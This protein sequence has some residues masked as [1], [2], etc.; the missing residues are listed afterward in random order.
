[1]VFFSCIHCFW[2]C[3]YEGDKSQIKEELF[4][5]SGEKL[6]V[7]RKWLKKEKA[8]VLFNKVKIGLRIRAEKKKKW[9]W[10]LLKGPN[11][12]EEQYTYRST[13]TA[14]DFLNEENLN[15]KTLSE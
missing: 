13:T 3:K 1:M 10:S 14:D 11:E 4:K 8:L 6:K 12:V 2:C 5:A 15:L 9:S 7:Y